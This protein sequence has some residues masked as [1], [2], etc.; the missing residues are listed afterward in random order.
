M[1]LRMLSKVA[2]TLV[3]SRSV[4]AFP[5]RVYSQVSSFVRD[6]ILATLSNFVPHLVSG[7]IASQRGK[8]EG[9]SLRNCKWS[10]KSGYGFVSINKFYPKKTFYFGISYFENRDTMID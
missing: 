1:F 2:F 3:L 6:E 4:Y 5:F 8:T 10:K 7:K 9:I